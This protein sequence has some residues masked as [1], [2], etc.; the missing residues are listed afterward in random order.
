M[1]DEL[2]NLEV[3]GSVYPIPIEEE[4]QKSYFKLMPCRLSWRGHCPDVRDGLKPVHRRILYSMNDMG[5]HFNRQPRKAV[6]VVGDVLAKIP[7]ARRSIGLRCFGAHG[8]ALFAARTD[9]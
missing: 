6:R 7:P 8:P 4:V 2:Q 5:L 9:D 1:S 3:A